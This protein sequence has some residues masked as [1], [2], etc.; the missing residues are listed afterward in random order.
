MA[1]MVGGRRRGR[2][3][4][5]RVGA[6]DPAPRR[7][8]AAEDRR[9]RGRGPLGRDQHVGLHRGRCVAPL[10]R[11][12][13]PRIRPP[14]VADRP[15]RPRLR[16]PHAAAVGWRRVVAGVARRGAVDR[17]TRTPCWP[18]RPASTRACAPAWPSRT[19]SGSSSPTGS[20]PVDA[21]VTRC[22]STA[23]CSSTSP[24]SRWTGTTPS[25]GGAVRGDAAREL[26]DARW[27]T[28]VEPGHR[29]PLRLHQPVGD[30]RG[31]LR[32][33]HGPRRHRRP[34]PC[35]AAA[36]RHPAPA[37]RGRVLLDRLR[38]AGRGQLAG[39]AHDVHRG[40]GHPGRRRPLQ[41]QR[42]APAS[43][44]A[45]PWRPTS[46]RSAWSA[47]ARQPSGSPASPDVRRSTRIE[48][49]ASTSVK[50]PLARAGR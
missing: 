48:P 33:G 47:A 17:S 50:A 5:L 41:R 20:S 28:F 22:A 49:T 9:R 39:R 29:H 10:A 30:R 24:S 18:A 31:D 15:S 6:D 34:R 12:G 27:D 4:G 11:H 44:G 14:H 2:G 36:R 7:V 13:R 3:A 42:L 35:P 26:I 45:P 46:R 43:C 23:T 21:S 38:L 40:R 32:A 16:G 19:W 1:L 37:H 25:S 8:L